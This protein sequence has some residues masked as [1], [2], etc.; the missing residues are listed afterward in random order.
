VTVGRT[1]PAELPP[2]GLPGLDPQWSR[3]VET[4]NLDGVGRTWHILDNQVENP[5]LT[6]LCVHG[7]PTWSYLWRDVLATAPPG[8][9]VVAVDQLD[10]GFSERTGTFRRFSQRIDDLSVLTDALDLTG[11]IVTLAH[12][13]GGAIALGWAERHV[14]QV[15]GVVLTNTAVHQPEGSAA[16][17][18]IRLI[19]VR[20]LLHAIC[21]WS[22]TFLWGTLALARPRLAKPIRRAYLTP[23]R[24]SSRRQAIANFVKDI[25]LSN[26]H[27]TQARLDEVAADLALLSNTPSLLL[28]GASDPVFSDRYLHDLKG[29]LPH[30]D[31]H[32]FVGAS[33]L[34]VED[35]GVAS[36][37]HRWIDQLD[38]QPEASTRP[39]R[40][41]DPLWAAID[42]RKDDDEAAII[43]MASGAAG[44]SVTF[45]ELAD[46]VRDVAAGLV[47]LGVAPG[48]R[49]AILVPPGIDLAV[50]IYACWRMGAV[51][52]VADAGLGVRG[53][54][55]ALRSANAK[56]LIGIPKALA[57]AK[58]LRWPGVR[59]SSKKISRIQSRTLGAVDTL[60]KLRH[61]GKRAPVPP[62]PSSLDD[63][64]ILFTSGST[65]PAKGVAYS[66]H[67][68]QAQ[69]D[70][71]VDLYDLTSSDRLVAAFGP[72]ALFG[73][74]IGILTVVPDMEVTSPG[75]LTAGAL[76]DAAV[77]VDATLIFGSPAALKNVTKTAS[78]LTECQKVALGGVRL[79]TSAGAPVP[80]A[81]LTDVGAII[82]HAALHT[83]YGMT[84]ALP[85]A[86]IGFDEIKVAGDGT[87]VCVG[88]T[89]AGVEVV[90]SPLDAAGNVTG[91]LTTEADVV[92]EVC[93]RAAHIREGYDGL[94]ITADAA[95]L[96][97][98]F[99]RSGDVG[100]LDTEGRLWIEGR[101]THLIRTA[102]G[103]VTP[104]GIEQTVAGLAD[105]ALAA[106]VGVGPPGNQQ[107]V[108]VIVPTEPPKRPNLAD[109]SLAA[110]VRAPLDVD[111]AAVL[112]V[113]ELPVDVR[114]NS[115]IDR[116]R[117]AAWAEAIL[118]GSRIGRL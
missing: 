61:R 65:G 30:A 90:I 46:D 105:V 22:P 95:S 3:L 114:H 64:A 18:L 77:A 62:E 84:E 39:D 16:P 74:G 63:A 101:V 76:A 10:M 102:A 107:V 57:A 86:D 4:P 15:V 93:V 25:P 58:V 92:G 28:W 111:V 41:R 100:H 70:A 104:I 115:K 21:Q 110:S 12:D 17:S 49:V 50:C 38:R 47:D 56:Y 103:P 96:D 91:Q 113:P 98:G 85:V 78:D 40:N 48:D 23:Y 31:V 27:P 53:M 19:R 34:V 71:I 72:F 67:Q 43:E 11:P 89:V 51:V 83:P 9:R 2:D 59:V 60:A 69:R 36:A 52:V 66:H 35:A 24:G 87:G 117:I 80:S 1:F 68:L 20:G 5:K 106:A 33:H 44:R 94:W 112:V 118:A 75:T 45:T 13:W 109:P 116:T 8:V 32:R 55:R 99:H 97:G 26:R 88:Q 79:V 14:D 29:R 42:R 73:P 37:V 82:P 7:N 54:G 81:T 108:L 6:L